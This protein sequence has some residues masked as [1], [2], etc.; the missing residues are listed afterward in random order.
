MLS[1]SLPRHQQIT[2]PLIAAFGFFGLGVGSSMEPASAQTIG[3]SVGFSTQV[4][5]GTTVSTE[6][7]VRTRRGF[8]VDGNNVLPVAGATTPLTV[9][10]PFQINNPANP[11]SLTQLDL[12]GQDTRTVQTQSS[13]FAAGGSTNLSVFANF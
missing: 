12:T 1:F 13:T 7:D 2:R 10:T 4:T 6:M 11:F 3:F 5:R 9:D 8:T